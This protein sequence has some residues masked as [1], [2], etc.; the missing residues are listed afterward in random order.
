MSWLED[1]CVRVHAR[2]CQFL[3]TQLYASDG[4]VWMHFCDDAVCVS[5]HPGLFLCA[6]VV[7]WL[8]M[9]VLPSVCS[10]II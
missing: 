5:E 1:V 10:G 7:M 3:G 9:H 6:H 8:Y 4:A 2:V